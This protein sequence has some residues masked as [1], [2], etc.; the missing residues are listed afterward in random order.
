[1]TV[2]DD[3]VVSQSVDVWR[4]DLIRTVETNVIPSLCNK[5]ISTVKKKAGGS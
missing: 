2:E 5:H 3:A 4:R 1:M